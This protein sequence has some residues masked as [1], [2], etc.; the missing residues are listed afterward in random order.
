MRNT[1]GKNLDRTQNVERYSVSLSSDFTLNTVSLCSGS[2]NPKVRNLEIQRRRSVTCPHATRKACVDVRTARTRENRFTSGTTLKND[3]V[4]REMA[5]LFMLVRL[6][7]GHREICIRSARSD[8]N[9]S[10]QPTQTMFRSQ[11]IY[12]CQKY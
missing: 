2:L 6:F 11:Y 3:V 8:R 1:C 10:K 12:T 9:E 5:D 4:P 7:F